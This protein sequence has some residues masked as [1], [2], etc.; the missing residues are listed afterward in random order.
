MG[1][2]RKVTG[3]GIAGSGIFGLFGS[4]VTCSSTDNS[5]YCNFLKLF[6]SL[7]MILLTIFIV[8]MVYAV[9][10]KP[11]IKFLKK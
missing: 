11:A 4:V 1:K 7:I 10:L 5:Y 9:L 6:N 8:Y 3:N 2:I